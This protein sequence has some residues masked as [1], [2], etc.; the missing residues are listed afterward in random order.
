[1]IWL[2]SLLVFGVSI[3]VPLE[4]RAATYFVTPGGGPG[5]DAVGR[6]VA[7]ATH[8]FDQST[9]A[10]LRPGDTLQLL[11]TAPDGIT[12]YEGRLTLDRV[13][14][15]NSLPITI[16]GLGARTKLIGKTIE[17]LRDCPMPEQDVEK[18]CDDAHIVIARVTK[19]AQRD[20]LV[21]LTDA[22]PD[23]ASGA[24][25]GPFAVPAFGAGGRLRK[26]ACIDLDRVD[27]LVIED[28][29]F[30]D[31]WLSAVRAIRSR[32]L[33]LRNALIRG[34]SYGLAV[35]GTKDRPADQITVEGVTWVQDTSGY[36][37]TSHK[38]LQWCTPA[39][40]SAAPRLTEL[41]CPG[42]MWRGLP[43]GVSHH[44]I[45]EHFNGA[46]LG[47]VDVTGDVVFRHNRVFSAFNGIRLK[48]KSCEDLLASNLTASTC[49]YNTRISIDSNDFSYVRDN[50]VEMEVFSR[51]VVILRNRLHN[52]HAWF[53]FDNMGGGPIYIF[54]NRG[55]FDDMPALP[56]SR[57]AGGGPACDRN[58][59]PKPEAGGSFDPMLDRRFN[60]ATATWLPVALLEQRA[61]GNKHLNVWMAAEEQLCDTSVVGRV[62]KFALP[63]VGMKRDTFRY[64]TLGAIYVFHNSWYLRA[65]VTS[66]AAIHTR[67]WNN[68]ILFCESG[69]PGYQGELC[70]VR[71]AKNCG[72]GIVKG[73]ELGPFRGERG[74][75]P[76]FDCFRWLPVDEAGHDRP[77]LESEF[78]FDVSANGFPPAAKLNPRF[79]ANGRTGDPGF[80]ASAAGDFRLKVGALA[81]RSACRIQDRGGGRLACIQVED[82]G[83]Y[84][85]A[86]APNGTLYPGPVGTL[87]WRPV[88][89]R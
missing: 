20:L 50:P 79:E 9:F 55:W 35:K 63:Q 24:L 53:S 72:R 42:R 54:A 89:D 27:G 75:L 46:L 57:N 10:L 56:W 82:S 1:M 17:A 45:T 25:V 44:G 49:P 65:P 60:Y 70:A 34:G 59:R 18:N 87:L 6:E 88:P 64:P 11:A 19:G 23:Q 52:A 62:L 40:S 78:D 43:W 31:C 66:D 83:S 68:A 4:A 30:E 28:L 26:A 86:F 32:R 29:D 47:G 61:V 85:G 84:V 7:A 67:H 41:G 38:G 22:A 73:E 15:A 76:F 80:I 77:D 74:T 13:G 37:E 5:Y 14:T 3:S 33:T 69:T 21:A 81:G 2:L 51:D 71:P 36:I 58:P 39:T 8:R 48:A 12:S 16:K